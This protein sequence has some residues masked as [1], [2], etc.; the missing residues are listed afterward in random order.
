MLTSQI[1]QKQCIQAMEEMTHW[2]FDFYWF[3]KRH[4]KDMK[5]F[6]MIQEEW[7]R[8]IIS[9]LWNGRLIISVYHWQQSRDIIKLSAW[10]NYCIQIS[11]YHCQSKWTCKIAMSCAMQFPNERNVKSHLA[12]WLFQ[13]WRAADHYWGHVSHWCSQP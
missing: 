7:M 11:S 10:D 4:M 9:I 1:S 2:S 13:N 6:K 12:A 5:L 3:G 8:D